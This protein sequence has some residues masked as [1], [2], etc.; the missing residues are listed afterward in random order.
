MDFE[1]LEKEIERLNTINTKANYTS[2]KRYYS[3]YYS[4][5]HALLEMEK[6]GQICTEP[7]SKSLG[8]LRE[9]QINDGPEFSC[10][11]VF[12]NKDNAAK[13]YKIGVCIRGL[14]ICK[15]V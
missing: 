12:W 13:K 14:P 7:G 10:T 6:S 9:L 8:Y 4:I 1:T 5:Y 11:I 2:R 3:L 15:P